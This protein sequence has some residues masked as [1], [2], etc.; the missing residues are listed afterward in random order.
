MKDSCV[1]KVFFFT[2]KHIYFNIALNFIFSP[3][4]R[5]LVNLHFITGNMQKAENQK[6]KVLIAGG[7]GLIGKALACKLAE[8][9]YQV[10]ILS[11]DI[12]Q[13]SNYPLFYWNIERS[14]IDEK[15]FENIDYLINLSGE[16]I[17]NKRWTK[18][19][20]E[21]IVSS[22]VQSAE[23]LYKTATQLNH[24]P[25]AYISA[26][27]IGY[28]GTFNASNSHTETSKI[29]TDFLAKTC[30]QWEE[31]AFQFENL[32]VRTVVLRTGVVFSPFEGAFPKITN[33]LSYGFIP[34]LG[35]G[36]QI[37]PW[38]HV[39]DLIDLYLFALENEDCRAV[40][41]AVAPETISYKEIVKEIRAYS[42]KTFPFPAAP[43]FV[44]K[45]ILGEMASILLYGAPISPEK[46]QSMGFHFKHNQFKSALQ[47]LL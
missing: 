19:Q 45:L 18:K 37:V 4:S 34:V 15:A 41:N 23:L 30:A 14:E 44:L 35:N 12:N 5:Y 29:G 22:R 36:N 21:K 3:L 33:S 7:T 24:F 32:K 28:Y 43:S 27:A 20:K 31:A 13:A 17:S 40:Y 1:H 6:K 16:N 10:N 8:K 47:Q 26:G 11:R 46:I 39:D 9:G 2:K 38:I 42:G 25:K